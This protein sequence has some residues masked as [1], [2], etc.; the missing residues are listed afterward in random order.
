[1][2]IIRFAFLTFFIVLQL[3]HSGYGEVR[4]SHYIS[5]EYIRYAR[6]DYVALNDKLSDNSGQAGNTADTESP[7]RRFEI[8]FFISLPF[9]FILTFATLHTYGVV[10]K[11]NTAV[12][13]WKD[14]RPALLIGTLGISSA[15]AVREAWITMETNNKKKAQSLNEQS[16]YFY[17]CKKF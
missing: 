2:K 13:V 10:K 5:D 7:L 4:Y 16:Y 6:S 17:A 15:I 9:V 11:Q 12:S 8:T 3:I 14:Y 1:M